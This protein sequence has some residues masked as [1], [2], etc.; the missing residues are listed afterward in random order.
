MM[1]FY[2]EH[3]PEIR[4]INGTT[5]IRTDLY[6]ELDKEFMIAEGGGRKI[7]DDKS[8]VY[9]GD[10]CITDKYIYQGDRSVDRTTG[11]IGKTPDHL[12]IRGGNDYVIYNYDR[13]YTQ[14]FDNGNVVVYSSPEVHALSSDIK[15]TSKGIVIQ[16]DNKQFDFV[17]LNGIVYNIT[18]PSKQIPTYKITPDGKYLAILSDD[19]LKIFY[20]TGFQPQLIHEQVLNDSDTF[21]RSDVIFNNVPGYKKSI[22]TSLLNNVKCNDIAIVTTVE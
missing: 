19:M 4:V 14:V 5:Y 16:R 17:S 1:R 8:I 10:D 12:P 22:C 9:S 3:E 15:F 21:Y 6:Y 7:Y 13:K 11:T 2:V 20:I 18:G